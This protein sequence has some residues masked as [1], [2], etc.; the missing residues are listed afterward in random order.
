MHLWLL[1][2]LLE[3]E[4]KLIEEIIKIIFTSRSH[5]KLANMLVLVYICFMDNMYELYIL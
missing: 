1:N 5:P 4:I 3:E 2:L